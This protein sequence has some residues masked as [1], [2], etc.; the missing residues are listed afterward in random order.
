[1]ADALFEDPRLAQVYDPLDPDRSDLD[2]YVDMCSELCAELAVELGAAH[3][4]D[5]GCGTGAFAC[6]LAQRGMRVT[7]VDPARAS[8]DVA[9]A[10]PG[11]QAVHWLLG[12]AT[13]LPP[14]SA[15]LAF[16]TANVA[17]VFL[18]DDD[19]MATLH[20]IREALR[21]GGVLV[22]ETRDPA[23]QAWL[24]WT[25]AHTRK[26]VDVPGV[27]LVEAW[28]ELIDVDGQLVTFR[29]TT[30][31]HRGDEADDLVVESLSTLRF[32]DRSDVQA[33]LATAGYELID[34]GDAPDR[35]GREMV[36]RCR[37][38]GSD[39]GRRQHP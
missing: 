32:R 31:F 25:P 7:A 35:P 4:L 22:F 34:V 14:L 8:L 18:T 36:F 5:V 9:R 19:W 21:P 38:P 1:V 23:R 24:D 6:M 11:A 2:V 29:W 30:S 3:V 26:Q 33:S 27:G 28:A 37:T 12:D 16:M 20:G 39:G 15:D 10:K 17:Q 13:T